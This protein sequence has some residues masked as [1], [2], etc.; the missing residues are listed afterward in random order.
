MRTQSQAPR[1][2]PRIGRRNVVRGDGGFLLA[3]ACV[4]IAIV[5][6]V[7]FVA[8]VGMG[9][10]EWGGLEGRALLLRSIRALV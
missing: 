8:L 10:D 3:L 6:Y 7:I 5:L 2:L 4:A 1:G 9:D